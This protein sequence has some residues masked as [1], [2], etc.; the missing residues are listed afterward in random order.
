[1]NTFWTILR[2]ISSDERDSILELF[3]SWS[4]AQWSSIDGTDEELFDMYKQHGYP[5]EITIRRKQ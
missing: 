2:H 1:M 4:S 5:T 3:V